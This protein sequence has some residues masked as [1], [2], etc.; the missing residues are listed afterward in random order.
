MELSALLELRRKFRE[1]LGLLS[2]DELMANPALVRIVE[3]LEKLFAPYA[4]V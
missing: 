2:V 3:R 4:A 1:L